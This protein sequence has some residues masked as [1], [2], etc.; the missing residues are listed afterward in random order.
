MQGLISFFKNYREISFLEALQTAK[1][2]ALEMDIDTSFR[3][4][5]EIKR[6]RHFD[7][8][9]DETNIATQSPEESFRITYFLPIVDQAVSSQGDLNSIKAIRK[10][11]DS[12][13]ILKY[14]NH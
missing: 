8:N 3:R 4:R 1:D 14:C 2:I 13:L 12:Y 10:F 5:C 6:K 11:L 7:E 9:P